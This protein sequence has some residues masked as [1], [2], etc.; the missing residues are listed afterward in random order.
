MKR[1]LLIVLGLTL[2]LAAALFF[3][4]VITPFTPAAPAT[5]TRVASGMTRSEIIALA[6][7][8]QTGGY[9]EK[10][11]ETWYISGG[12]GTRQMFVHYDGAGKAATV[13][14]GIF[15]PFGRGFIE[16]RRTH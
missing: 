16:T 9:P 11:I 2:I 13:T 3:R 14:E 4:G 1:L 10:V 15:W 5:W 7:P 8:P 6:G 12:V